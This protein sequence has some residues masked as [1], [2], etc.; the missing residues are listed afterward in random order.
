M[1]WVSLVCACA[2]PRLAVFYTWL[3][4]R[5]S[6]LQAFGCRWIWPV[7]GVLF[8]SLTTLAWVQVRKSDKRRLRL[9][10]VPAVLID[11]SRL[12]GSGHPHRRRASRQPV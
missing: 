12:G 10:F 11:L 5:S 4:R 9:I 3:T 7:L 6:F 1:G 2:F 8:L